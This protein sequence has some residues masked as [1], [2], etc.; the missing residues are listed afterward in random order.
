MG[1]KYP[2]EAVIFDLDGVITKTASLHVKAWKSV[3]DE[4]LHLRERRNKEKFSE[5]TIEKDYLLYVDGK[6]RYQ[7]AKSFL[8]SRGINLPF[9]DPLD[10]P[11]KETICGLGNKK[12][13]KFLELVKEQSVEVY[14]STIEFIKKLKAEGIKVGVASSSKSCQ[15]ILKSADIENL[16]DVRVNGEISTRLQLKGKPE[17]DIF[18]TAANQLGVPLSKTVVVED[19]LSGVRAGRNAAAALVIGVARKENE[20]ELLKGGAD[21]VVKDLSQINLEWIERWFHKKPLP[22]F[23][24]RYQPPKLTDIFEDFNLE[25]K[26]VTI[27]PAYLRSA[28]TSLFS[29]KRLFFSL[30]YDGTL[31]SIVD[32]PELARLS[33]TMREIIEVLV[34]RYKVAVIS[35]RTRE[36]IEEL[37]GIRKIIY[38]GNHGLDIAGE[39]ISMVHPHAEQLLPAIV[40]LAEDLQKE[41]SHIKGILIEKKKFSVAIH[42]RL[43]EEKW[44]E[45]IESLVERIIQDSPSFRLLR[46]K[47]VLEI[48]PSV[49]WNKGKALRWIIQRLG[50]SWEGTTVVHI[51]DDA[52]DEDVF[53]LVRTR[54]I[55]ILVSPH[56]QESAADFRLS[57][58]EEVKKLLEEIINSSKGKD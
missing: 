49:D 47:K 50:I 20:Q 33:S 2:F 10:P 42:W 37:V 58:P 21:V 23:S 1:K 14:S 9:G 3:F 35:G 11:D 39:G 52:T 27:N 16:F 45:E 13:L 8:D 43:V 57:S 32:R 17:G 6:P 46:G 55:G 5:F 30:D 4:Y 54:G 22:L 36:N 34:Q 38:A 48:M 15:H 12:N 28:Q 51:G 41:L 19:A 18:V 44:V 29:Q 40:R 7:G 26:K 56:P 25:E 31:T 53:R 24:F